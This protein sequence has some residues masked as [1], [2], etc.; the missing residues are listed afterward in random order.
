MRQVFKTWVTPS[1]PSPQRGEKSTFF[2][3]YTFPIA[4]RTVHLPP[5]SCTQTAP[6]PCASP[7]PDRRSECHFCLLNTLPP[8]GGSPSFLHQTCVPMSFLCSL[9]CKELL[10][11]IS[12]IPLISFA[13][14]CLCFLEGRTHFIALGIPCGT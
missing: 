9:L 2:F 6:E 8:L 1:V 10:C 3:F 14:A 7:F 5:L 4:E 13:R 12:C 11:A